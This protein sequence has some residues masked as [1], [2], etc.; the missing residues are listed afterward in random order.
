VSEY[1]TTTQTVRFGATLQTSR[2]YTD[3]D[4]CVTVCLG[5]Y[6]LPHMCEEWTI[7]NVEDVTAL[8]GLLN[9]AMGQELG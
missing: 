4:F 7:G 9:Y 5:M 2:I 1:K 8:I 3:G 6:S